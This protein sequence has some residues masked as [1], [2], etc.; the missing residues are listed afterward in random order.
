VAA[1]AEVGLTTPPRYYEQVSQDKAVDVS[2]A[3]HP[4][5]THLTLDAKK[6]G[7]DGDKSSP[8]S[9]PRKKTKA[10]KSLASH[11]SADMRVKDQLACMVM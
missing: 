11:S 10:T 1:D 2:H 4:G 7:S 8:N 3:I 5:S 6:T 9:S